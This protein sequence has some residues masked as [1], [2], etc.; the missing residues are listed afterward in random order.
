M[1]QVLLVAGLALVVAG[2]AV[3]L[4][5]WRSWQARAAADRNAERYLAWRGRGDRSAPDA[6]IPMTATEQR[7]VVVAVAIGVLGGIAVVIGLT[8]G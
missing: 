4:P 5:A 6:S 1:S 7:R 8:A 2:L 3:G